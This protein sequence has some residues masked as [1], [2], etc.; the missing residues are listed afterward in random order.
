MDTSEPRDTATEDVLG[1]LNAIW[2]QAAGLVVYIAKAKADG[3][4]TGFE[5]VGV[6]S[7]AM[8]LAE[9][10]LAMIDT[11]HE[12]VKRALPILAREAR[13][14]LPGRAVSLH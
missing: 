6:S 10:I 3:R 14:V 11:S 13:L 2:E 1:M 12:D 5:A 7:R 8:T 4:F 9:M